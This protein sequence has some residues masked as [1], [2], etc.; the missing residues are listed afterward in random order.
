MTIERKSRR[1]VL[2]LTF[3][4]VGLVSGGFVS[5]HKRTEDLADLT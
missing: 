1:E 5:V 2:T 3:K 4:Y